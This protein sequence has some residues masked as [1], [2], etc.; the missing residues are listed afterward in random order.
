MATALFFHAHPD[1]ECILTGGTM[2]QLAADGHRVVHRSQQSHDQEPDRRAALRRLCVDGRCGRSFALPGEH[3]MK[4]AIIA[5]A[6][7]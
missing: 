4:C 1:D 2:A 6:V 7:L 5:I 3:A